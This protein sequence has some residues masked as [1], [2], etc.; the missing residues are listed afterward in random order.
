MQELRTETDEE[1]Q[2]FVSKIKDPVCGKFFGDDHHFHNDVPVRS[3]AIEVNMVPPR[4]QVKS[5][6]NGFRPPS[7]ANHAIAFSTTL[8]SVTARSAS[9]TLGQQ[10][11]PLSGENIF[12]STQQQQPRYTG[13]PLDV[14]LQ[15]QSSH[16]VTTTSHYVI[17]AS[18][19]A[20]GL[21]LIAILAT[22]LVRRM[23]KGGGK[24]EEV[25]DGFK[26][27]N[28]FSKSNS[29]RPPTFLR[30]SLMVRNDFYYDDRELGRRIGGVSASEMH[31]PRVLLVGNDQYVNT[32]DIDNS[33][34]ERVS[35]L[36]PQHYPQ[37]RFI[38][39]HQIDLGEKLGEGNFGT[40]YK[41]NW[42]S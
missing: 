10:L 40:V 30:R 14:G 42:D 26:L 34:Q 13:L 33:S 31:S 41:G 6:V 4:P 1:L 15:N 27:K 39:K 7:E 21:V 28:F 36:Q 16:D 3:P 32:G 23:N 37:L 11:I 29:F 9:D 18:G 25:N 2:S 20:I 17:S 22:V 5:R 35:L 24:T 19:T 12:Q 38:D 8:N